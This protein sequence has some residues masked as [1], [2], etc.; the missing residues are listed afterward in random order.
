MHK[1]TKPDAHSVRDEAPVYIVWVYECVCVYASERE[2]VY[3]N[4]CVC[5]Y[6]M[7]V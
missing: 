2:C 4:G 5:V 1:K 6:H 3:A 7:G